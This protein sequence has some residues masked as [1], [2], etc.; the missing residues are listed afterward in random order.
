MNVDS[1]NHI[2]LCE[3]LRVS[4]A[5]AAPRLFESYGRRG[6]FTDGLAGVLGSVH[7]IANL[8]ALCLRAL[9]PH[10]DADEEIVLGVNRGMTHRFPVTIGNDIV[11]TGFVERADQAEISFA[12]QACAHGRLA[13]CGKLQFGVMRIT[14][15]DAWTPRQAP[16]QTPIPPLPARSLATLV[17]P[18]SRTAALA[19]SAL[20]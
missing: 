20:P 14:R 12:I 7:L 9:Q 10:L 15:S 17:S 3:R 13:A 19:R 8:E 16:K 6:R 5:Q 11:V 18:W 4:A 2:V 1:I